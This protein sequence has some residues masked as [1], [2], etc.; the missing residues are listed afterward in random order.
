MFNSLT[1]SFTFSSLHS[2]L[3]PS[4]PLS[5]FP[6]FPLSP[7]SPPPFSFP[8]LML[9]SKKVSGSPLGIL[10]G[11]GVIEGFSP[12]E[13]FPVSQLPGCRI[14]WDKMFQSAKGIEVVDSECILSYATTK[15]QGIV[16]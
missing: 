6:S 5:L 11:E 3:F 15:P 1:L 2:S 16:K 7:L 4:F 10:K 9:Y 14:V 8:G 12:A 13:I